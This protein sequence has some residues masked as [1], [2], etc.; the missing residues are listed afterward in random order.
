VVARERDRTDISALW[1]GQAA[2][3]VHHRRAAELLDSLIA[4]V[5]GRL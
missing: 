4:G 3:L 1:A 2:N 5:S